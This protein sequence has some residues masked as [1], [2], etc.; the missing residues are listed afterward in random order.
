VTLT[1][2]VPRNSALVAGNAAEALVEALQAQNVDV[3]FL[4]PGTDT[5]PVQEAFAALAAA[6]RPTPR[7]VLCRHEAVALAAAHAYFA[8]TGRPQVVMVHVDVGTQN[9]GAMLHNAAR[10]QAGVVVIA[11]LTPRTSHGEAPGG[12]DTVV[13]WQQDVPDQAGIVRGYVK[14]CGDLHSAGT[15]SA[16]LARAFQVAAATP[17][18]PV[19]LTVAR[20][21]LMA[22]LP[23]DSAPAGRRALPAPMAPDPATLTRAVSALAGAARPVIVTSRV[24]RNVEAVPELAAVAEL[25]GAPVVE[26]RDRMNLPSTH[27]CYV[28]DPRRAAELLERADV[29]LVVDSDVPWVPSRSAPPADATV[30]QLD[31]DPVK[32]SMPGWDFPVD[33]CLQ[34][35]PF[36]GLR[37]LAA[38]L[39][40]LADAGQLDPR[41]LPT[42]TATTVPAPADGELTSELVVRALNGLL[43]EDDLLLD[44]SV[45][46]TEV[47]RGGLRRTQPGTAFQCGGSGLGWAIPGAIG[48]RLAAPD[49]RAVA[50][51]GDG[52]F[53][54]SGPTAALLTARDAGTPF[55]VVVLAN[56]GYAASRR[57]VFELFPDG[58]SQRAG[59]VIGTRFPEP[60]D[61]ALLARACHAWG[62]DVHAAAD[63]EP[64]LQRAFAALENERCAVVVAHVGS[65]WI[66]RREPAGTPP[67]RPAPSPVPPRGDLS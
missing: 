22:P 13:H 57:P 10:A 18:G 31:A 61:T 11:G 52:T 45:T 60:P 24:G 34:A 7:V 40:S 2:Q 30:I 59:D 19:Y 41:P 27:P 16:Q 38:E 4:N 50:V 14:W 44:E 65:P 32:V 8:V 47:V 26:R 42:P 58:A 12:R 23:A 39:R 66:D 25:L 55:L 5:A 1:E 29:V 20:E 62:E 9:L 48:A 17:S 36:L 21:V 33:L 53:L 49:R 37:A 51:V 64:A 6:G 28:A 3:V 56:G 43:R 67:A 63:I 15:I 46:N 35:D 54:F